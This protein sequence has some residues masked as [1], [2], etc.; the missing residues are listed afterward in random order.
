MAGHDGQEGGRASSQGS[1][2]RPANRRVAQWMRDYVRLP[3]IPDE[4]IA[5]DGAPR[6]VWT[7]FFDAF[8]TLSPGRHRAAVRRRR[9]SSAG[10]RRDLPRARRDRRPALAAE[11]SAAADR[12]GR[13]A[14]ID[15]R[16]RRSA[17]N[18]WNWCWAISTARAAWSPKARSRPRPL[19]AAPNICARSAA[20]NRRAAAI[21]V[22]T[23]PMSAAA[24]TG[25]GGCSAT[26]PRRPRAPATRW[27][28]GWCCRAPSPRSTSR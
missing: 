3:G 11:P 23:P 18:C 13:L 25:A 14:A 24:P 6:A 9:P 17:R 27:K 8:A 28:T 4:Y 19:P 22:S 21:S 12:R 5:Q 16:H 1:R 26:A 10:S 7:R 20:S 2:A 15:R